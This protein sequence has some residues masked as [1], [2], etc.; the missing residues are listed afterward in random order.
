VKRLLPDRKR[1]KPQIVLTNLIDV[2][3]L[4]VFFFMI[5]SSFAKEKKQLPIQLPKA[6][7]GAVIESET[8]SFQIDE[9]GR[10]FSGGAELD[11]IQVLEKVKEY[12]SGSGDRPIVVEADEKVDYGKVVFLLDLVK[13]S[14]GMN[15]GLATRQ[16]KTLHSRK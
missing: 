16:E 3:L 9:K 2:I 8:L 6:A 5:T 14:G 12:V 11:S 15:I 4:L 13:T 1:E 10:I 7:S